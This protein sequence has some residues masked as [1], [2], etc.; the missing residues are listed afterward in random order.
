MRKKNRNYTQSD[1]LKVVGMYEDGYG[2]RIISR[3]TGI[4]ENLIAFWLRCY[5]ELGLSGL[6]KRSNPRLSDKLKYEIVCEIRTKRLSLQAASIVYGISMTALWQWQKKFL[7]NDSSV[8]T[9]VSELGCL[10]KQMGRPKKKPPQSEFEKLQ[11]EVLELKA[12]LAFLKKVRALVEQRE[13]CD[14]VIVPKPSKY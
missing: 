2:C 3:E 9:V 10:N 4:R 14:N 13:N 6:Q 7:S 1:K 8:I 12:E 5:R 11:L